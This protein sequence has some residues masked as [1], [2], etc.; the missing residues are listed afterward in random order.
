[1]NS[2][3]LKTQNQ[4]EK[5]QNNLL[6]VQFTIIKIKFLEIASNVRLI[7]FNVKTHQFVMNVLQ[8]ILYL[9]KQIPVN[10]VILLALVVKELRLQTVF[11]VLKIKFRKGLWVYWAQFM[12]TKIA[13][14][15]IKV[16]A[17][18]KIFINCQNFTNS[19]LKVEKFKINLTISSI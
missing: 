14:C 5:H 17:I 12:T 9:L 2:L 13:L 10:H 1:V 7:V 16:K 8:D 3:V 11:F 19:R 15:I 4:L 6:L 18:N